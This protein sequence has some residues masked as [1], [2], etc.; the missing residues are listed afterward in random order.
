MRR[1]TDD[2]LLMISCSPVA[3]LI[4]PTEEAAEVVRSRFVPSQGSATYVVGTKAN[5][6][7]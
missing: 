1:R 7:P 5:C 4:A 2:T 6:C 3:Q